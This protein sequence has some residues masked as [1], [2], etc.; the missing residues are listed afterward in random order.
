MYGPYL[1][2]CV[3]ITGLVLAHHAN[4]TVMSRSLKCA[5]LAAAAVLVLPSIMLKPGLLALACV[6]AASTSAV[7]SGV[8]RSP[9]DDPSREK[10][11]SAW[12]LAV[13]GA[14]GLIVLALQDYGLAGTWAVTRFSL[15]GP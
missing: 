9:K 7:V 12:D 3:T 4:G 1:A 2:A 11:W 8:A 5:A 14:A 6:L 10:T 13:A 15:P